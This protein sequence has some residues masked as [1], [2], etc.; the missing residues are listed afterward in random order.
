M[1]SR[2]IQMEKLEFILPMI[3]VMDYPLGISGTFNLWTK[4]KSTSSD[5]KI[6]IN[7]GDKRAYNQFGTHRFEGYQI[8]CTSG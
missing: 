6:T 2:Q 3:I 5:N 1:R 7:L 4:V 8:L